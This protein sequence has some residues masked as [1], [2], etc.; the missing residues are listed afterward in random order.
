M[1]P[2]D[3]AATARPYIPAGAG[4]E[5]ERH[6]SAPTKSR[7]STPSPSVHGRKSKGLAG[8]KRLSRN[9]NNAARSSTSSS[10]NGQYFALYD[11]FPQKDDELRLVQGRDVEILS[12]DK[13]DCGNKNWWMGRSNGQFGIF[14]SSYVVE[15]TSLDRVNIL[16]PLEIDFDE[17]EQKAF[18]GRGGFGKV[19]LYTWR[20]QEVKITYIMIS[21]QHSVFVMLRDEL[22]FYTSDLGS[23]YIGIRGHPVLPFICLPICPSLQ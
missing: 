12:K 5:P 19:Y 8:L 6:A 23:K 13:R 16:L 11:Y 22:L 7:T 2:T 9:H 3:R 21:S 14:P 4:G 1:Y 15:K 10:S 18:I 20:G 17:L